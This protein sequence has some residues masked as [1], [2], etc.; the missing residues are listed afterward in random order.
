MNKALKGAV[1]IKAFIIT[2]IMLVNSFS[3]CITAQASQPAVSAK[4]ENMKL[5]SAEVKA[6]DLDAIENELVYILVL[7]PEKEYSSLNTSNTSEYVAYMA[8]DVSLENKCEFKFSLAEGTPSGRYKVLVKTE[9]S[10]NWLESSFWYSDE[11]YSTQL[12]E[13]LKAPEGANDAEKVAYINQMLKNDNFAEALALNLTY[14]DDS[15]YETIAKELYKE[16][17]N[18]HLP[19]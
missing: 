2:L 7:Y 9:R 1:K 4:I 19:W 6:I 8:A 13:K 11:N 15:M 14:V 10:D 12:V 18:L 3:I 16:E 17:L 5:R